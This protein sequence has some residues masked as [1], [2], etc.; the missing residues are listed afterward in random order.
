MKYAFI[1]GAT[2]GIGRAFSEKLLSKGYYVVA[3]YY[4]DDEAAN[5]FLNDMRIKFGDHVS[6]LKHDLSDP[7]KINILVTELLTISNFY[8]VLVFN[9]GSTDRTMFPNINKER[10]Q[11]VFNTNLNVPVFLIQELFPFLNNH[12]NIIFTG[13]LMGEYP[14]SVSLAYGVSKASVHALVKNLVKFLVDKAIRVNAIVPGF[15]DTEWQ[16]E[17]PIE[18]RENIEKKIANG[19]FG[20]P[21]DVSKMLWSI[22]E[23]EY[24]NGQCIFVDGG[25]S[26]K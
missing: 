13:S 24:V 6:I 1:S 14:H 11:S 9:A 19:S 26:F 4:S 7:E 22:I 5:D 10:W 3:N 25:Y 20:N 17:K 8:D 16:K 18:I 21:V 2:K 12:S 15:I 23:N